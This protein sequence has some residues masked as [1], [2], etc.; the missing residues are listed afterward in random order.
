MTRFSL[1]KGLKIIPSVQT[2]GMSNNFK[3][4]IL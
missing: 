1:E 4:G 2:T 3:N